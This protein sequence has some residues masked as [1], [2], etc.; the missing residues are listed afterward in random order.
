[1]CLLLQHLQQRRRQDIQCPTLER[2]EAPQVLSK[3]AGL[4]SRQSLGPL[5]FASTEDGCPTRCIGNVLDAR[6]THVSHSLAQDPRTHFLRCKVEQVPQSV[7]DDKK[8][9]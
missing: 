6:L 9:T 5:T 4:L 3:P 8:R 1:M 7:W 2:R